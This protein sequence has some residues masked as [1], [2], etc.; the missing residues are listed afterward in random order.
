[1]RAASLPW[2]GCSAVS[3]GG[4]AARGLLPLEFDPGADAQVDLGEGVASIAGARAAVQLFVM[5]LCYSRRTFIMAF[6]SQRQEAFFDG[7]VRAF[8]H[9]QVVAPPHG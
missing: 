4:Q 7:H 2:G 8:Q 3:A 5:R 9:F 6:P 1:M